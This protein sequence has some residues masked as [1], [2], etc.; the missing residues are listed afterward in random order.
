V[1]YPEFQEA[2]EKLEGFF[3]G[4]PYTSPQRAMIWDFA[5]DIDGAE[6]RRAVD[7]WA[8][9]NNRLPTIIQLKHVCGDALKRVAIEQRRKSIEAYTKAGMECVA[10]QLTGLIWATLRTHISRYEYQF[11][12]GYCRSADLRG[13]SKKFPE[14]NRELEKQFQPERSVLATMDDKTMGDF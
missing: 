8:G 3:G 7:V 13:I 4:R 12:C 9:S 11:R 10:C 5:K 2:L 6:L 14:W 1:N